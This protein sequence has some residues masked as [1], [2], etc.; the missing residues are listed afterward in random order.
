MNEKINELARDAAGGMLSFDED[1][2]R[3]SQ[4]EAEKF[5][6]LIVEECCKIAEL[7]EQGFSEYH[8]DVSVGWYIRQRFWLEQ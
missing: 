4:K 8:P 5:C 3:L 7:K 1:G 6:K 2:F